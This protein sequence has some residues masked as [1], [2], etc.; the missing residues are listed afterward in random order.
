MTYKLGIH[1]TN[2]VV[3]ERMELIEMLEDLINDH[4]SYKLGSQKDK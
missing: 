2:D 3:R 4:I 1:V